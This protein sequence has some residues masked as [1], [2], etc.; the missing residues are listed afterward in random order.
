MSILK[1]VYKNHR[2]FF[3]R[4]INL[5]YTVFFFFFIIINLTALK[6]RYANRQLVSKTDIVLLVVF[7]IILIEYKSSFCSYTCMGR[8]Y[9]VE[10]TYTTLYITFLN[11]T[12]YPHYVFIL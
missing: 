1:K 4:E 3:P 9:G 12:A 5:I 2:S 8:Y 10:I 6:F 11:S 7:I